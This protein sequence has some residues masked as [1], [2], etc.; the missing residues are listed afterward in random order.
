MWLS[1][2]ASE[3]IAEQIA[4]RL[5]QI[6]PEQQEKIANNLAAFK[7]SLATKHAAISTQL[8]GLKGKGYY[9]FHDAYRY[10]ENTYGLTS[11][12]SFTI[13]PSVAPGA[14]T[15]A[16]IKKHVAQHKAQCLFTEP[17]F[18]PKVV[19]SLKKGTNAKVGQLDPLG[20]HIALGKDAY[21]QFL[22]HLADQFSGCLAN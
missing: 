15:L 1:P 18:T 4:A 22:Q 21:P 3:T 12:G 9:T 11:L 8:A 7:T 17:Q 14:K 5:T 6:M 13:N 2:S 20:Q 10:F 16:K 19:A